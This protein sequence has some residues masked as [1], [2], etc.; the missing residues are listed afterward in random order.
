[1]ADPKQYRDNGL[2]NDEKDGMEKIKPRESNT[3]GSMIDL[4]LNPGNGDSSLLFVEHAIE[5]IGMGAFQ[6]KLAFTCAFGFIVDQMLL[7]SISLVPAQA[8]AEF[9]P[10][11]STLI[12]PF[13]Y[14]GLFLGAIVLGIMAD[15]IGRKLVWQT[16]LFAVCIFVM[17]AAGSPSWGALTGFVTIYGFFAGGNL[18]ID[19][20]LL[21]ECLPARYSFLLTGMAAVWGLG[22][23]ITGLIAWPLLVNF[24][25][26]G[27]TPDTCP[28]S[29]NMGWRYLYITLGGLCLLMAIGRALVLSGSESPKW[30][31]SRGRM[32]EAV[33]VLNHISATN[34]SGYHVTMAQLSLP[35]EAISRKDM[36]LKQH[37]SRISHL[38]RGRHKARLMVCLMLLW[39]LVGIC[40]PLFTIFLSYYLQAHG[41]QLGDGSAYQTYRDWAITSVVGIFGPVL[42]MIMV[43]VPWLRSRRSIA[44]TACLCAVFSGVFTIV[45]NEAQ[46]LAFSCLTGFWL[47]ALYSIIYSYTPQA[48]STENRGFGNGL[49]M[50]CGRL[51][52]LTA[53]FIATFADVTSPVPLF[54][55]CGMYVVMGIIG[56]LLSFETSGFGQEP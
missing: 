11:Y 34:G 49:L 36:S 22:N 38:F 18:A 41:V 46:N 55:S 7:V 12:S 21:A 39:M 10:Q 40:Y 35:E 31:A 45:A 28:K 54:V 50:A 27:S 6:W 4:G 51:A 8:A 26:S 5:Q 53:P 44:I 19:L 24:S 14:A 48:L 1:M 25:C 13:N 52:S 29:E 15:T 30:L 17:T 3:V 37:L 56:I 33:A 16:S 23:A 20:T 2:L 42:S 32:E 43:A 9:G 47:N